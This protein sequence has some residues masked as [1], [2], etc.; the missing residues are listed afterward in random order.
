MTAHQLVDE[1]A[2][3]LSVKA[4]GLCLLIGAL[5]FA[6]ARLL[7]GDT[8]AADA[9]AALTF[10]GGRSGYAAVHIVAVLAA[11]T[12][13]IGITALANSITYPSAWLLSRA[14]TTTAVIGT[15][16]FGVESTSE[17][18]A[19]PE[20]A[21]VA[22]ADPSQRAE[23][24]RAARAV[25]TATHGPS[26]VAIALFIGAT[27]LLIGLA[28]RLNGYPSWLG[29]LGTVIG[30]VTLTASVGLYLWPSLFPGSL[31]YGVLASV[32]AQLWLAAVGVV[33]LR[34]GLVREV[35]AEG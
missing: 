33:M 35:V 17:G 6:T 11:A 9:D 24:L 16:I 4:G 32:V 25:A 13:A 2:R 15:A 28:I 10:V 23:L 5:A 1:Q 14:G 18:L 29:I 20:L 26:L 3:T 30:A 19:L 22:Q 31:L 7:H 34:R 21:S 27:L 8:P 12:I